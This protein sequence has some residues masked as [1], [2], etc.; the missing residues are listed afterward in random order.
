MTDERATALHAKL[1]ELLP[2]GWRDSAPWGFPNQVELAL[3]AGVFRAQVPQH[4]VNSVVDT[5]MR[6][7][8]TDL[9]DDLQNTASAG[10]DGVTAMLGD[11]WGATTVL[12][13]P[14]RRAEVIHGAAVALVDVGVRTADDLRAACVEA[15]TRI[16][17]AVHA[18]RGLGKGTWESIAFHC[19]ARLRPDPEKVAFVSR[20]L[21]DPTLNVERTADL[22][23]K[24]ARRFAVEERTLR[25]AIT[26]YLHSAHTE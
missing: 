4:S 1:G 25:H 17:A 12:G 22:L 15:P 6:S 16:E 10:L 23:S 18:V 9:L 26:E 3:V 24:T 8:P 20:Q 21:D 11:R 7:R 2:A 19:H 14:V 13:V 5:F